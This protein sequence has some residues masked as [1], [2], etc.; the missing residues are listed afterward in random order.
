MRI[1]VTGAAGFIGFHLSKHLIGSG[2]EVT[3]IDNL[4]AAYGR[5]LPMLRSHLLEESFGV[6]FKFCDLHAID[7]QEILSLLEGAEAVVH[8]AA[9]PGV[10]QSRLQPLAYSKNNINTF[11]KVI[12]AV[13][14]LNTPKFVFA[15]S[16]SVYGNLGVNGPV[17]EDEADGK[18]LLSYYANT[19]WINELVAQHYASNY[20]ISATALRLFTVY[21]PLGR[22][23]MAYWKFADKLSR[24]EVIHLHGKSGGSR[25]FTFIED[26]V[27][28]IAALLQPEVSLV[29]TK[30]LNISNGKPSTTLELL[31]SLAKSLDI[32]T[33]EYSEIER[34]KD[35]VETTWANTLNLDRLIKRIPSTSLE[36]G[37]SRFVNWYQSF[38]VEKRL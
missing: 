33:F 14:V 26:V 23:D 5:S 15:S 37:I 30:S 38:D 2:N 13:R 19:K 28:I 6:Q 8:L 20:N 22:P 34:P 24:K 17:S 4:D 10:R 12:E 7:D 9:W 1:A 27:Q 3:L 31:N 32:T 35:D 36:M 25:C 18:N 11:N 16:S 29:G 21:G